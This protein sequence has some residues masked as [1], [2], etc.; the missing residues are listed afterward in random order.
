MRSKL[1]AITART[2]SRFGPFAA[3]SRDE[4]EPYSLPARMISGTFALRVLHAGVEDRHLLALGQQPRHAALGAR[5]QLVA[6]PHV[7][8]RPAHHHFV[9]AAPRPV[10][11]EVRRL[12]SMLGQVLPRRAVQP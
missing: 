7:G 3:Q 1:S 11:V 5:R 2:P 6:Q 10:A 4:P 12:H 9:I 8:E